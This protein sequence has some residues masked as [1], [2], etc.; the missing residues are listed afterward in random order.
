MI[1]DTG[2]GIA[3]MPCKGHCRSCGTNHINDYFAVDD[4]I[5]KYIY[6]CKTD[7]GC[8]CT[9]NGQCAFVQG[10]GEGSLYKG[11]IVKD[12][13]HFGDAYHPGLDAFDFTFGCVEEE[14]NLFYSQEADGILGMTRASGNMHMKPIFD[15]MYDAHLIEK[16][17]FSLCLG[18]NGGYFQI[19][20]YDATSHLSEKV[21]WVPMLAESAYNGYRMAMKGISINGHMMAGTHLFDRG[22]I[23][24]GTTFTYVPEKLFNTMI[25]HLD[26]YCLV[27]PANH[28]KGKRI[29]DGRSGQTNNICF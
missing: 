10:Y 29:H 24:S 7:M 4:S 16:R 27:D 18:K 6:Q 21:Q 23:D 14:T 17:M 26:W 12:T 25:E 22:V 19:G 1:V 8:T 13:F 20:G 9:E 2:S 15:V 11:F 3:A 5:S 28:C